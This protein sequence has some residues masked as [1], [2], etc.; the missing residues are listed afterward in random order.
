M[1]TRNARLKPVAA[2]VTGADDPGES[3]QAVDEVA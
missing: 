3:S 2:L 1:P